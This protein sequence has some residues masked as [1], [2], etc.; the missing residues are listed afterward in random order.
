MYLVFEVGVSDAPTFLIIYLE[1]SMAKNLHSPK[2]VQST[3]KGDHT[4]KHQPNAAHPHAVHA[5]S[6]SATTDATST[7]IELIGVHHHAHP[8]LVAV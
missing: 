7:H 1:N 6:Q 3:P 8:A 5:D 4:A 2:A